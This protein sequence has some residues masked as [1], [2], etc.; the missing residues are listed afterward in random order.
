MN[1]FA[2]ISGLAIIP[3]ASSDKYRH[4]LKSPSGRRRA[5]SAGERADGPAINKPAGTPPAPPPPLRAPA[6]PLARSLGKTLPRR[7]PVHTCACGGGEGTGEVLSARPLVC[8]GPWTAPGRATGP[9]WH[10][11]AWSLTE[12]KDGGP[13]GGA[14]G[15]GAAGRPRCAKHGGPIQASLGLEDSGTPGGRSPR[16]PHRRLPC[17]ARPL[18][19]STASLVFWSSPGCEAPGRLVQ[20][21]VAGQGLQRS[22]PG[23]PS[24][25]LRP[26][27]PASTSL[28]SWLSP[29]L[30][31]AS[32]PPHFPPLRWA[33][34]RIKAQEIPLVGKDRSW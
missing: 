23:S 22:W 33:R 34:N 25:S 1:V 12:G 3:T 5:G 8:Q 11:S 30:S 15:S 18:D 29:A 2:A 26:S 17:L 13:A 7:L 20:A 6:R 9:V 24:P 28:P 32:S 10:C 31:P 4:R 19:K 27:S 16:G 14:S 21:G